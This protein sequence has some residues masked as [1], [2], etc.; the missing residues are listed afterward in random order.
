MS[1]TTEVPKP[2]PEPDD[3]S[4]PFWEGTL[5]GKLLLMKCSD[6]GEFRIP[7]RQHCDNCLSDNYT[8]A[9]SS[10]RGVVRSLGV[11]HQKYHPAFEPEIPY[12]LAMVELEE[13]PRMPTNIVEL[14]GR[15]V[16]VGMPVEVTWER[17]ED[18][19]VPK[20]RPR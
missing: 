18:V 15:E 1:E 3:E 14:N 8:W 16:Q 5:E 2:I 7:S 6:C 19:A 11:M 17:H 10:G 9:E 12:T 4:R 13:G 20:F